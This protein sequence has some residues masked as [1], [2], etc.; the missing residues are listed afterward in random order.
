MSKK[1]QMV[2]QELENRGDTVLGQEVA[3]FLEAL[4]DKN[5]STELPYSRRLLA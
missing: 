5:P 1:I 2:L 4:Q 3:A